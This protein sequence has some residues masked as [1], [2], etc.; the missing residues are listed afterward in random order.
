MSRRQY[1]PFEFKGYLN[2]LFDIRESRRASRR[3][4]TP[5]AF[6]YPMKARN[7]NFNTSIYKLIIYHVT[8][9]FYFQLNEMKQ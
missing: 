3:H 7:L 1:P 6:H 2:R 8:D 4:K 9:L 5:S